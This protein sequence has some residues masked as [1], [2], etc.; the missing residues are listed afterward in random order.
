M[1]IDENTKRFIFDRL[2]WLGIYTGI[3]FLLLFLLPFPYD[4]FSILALF[5]LINFLRGRSILKSYG[6]TGGI[7]DSF[8][9]FSS[10]MSRN[11]QSRPLKY[12]CMNCGKEHKETAYPNCGSK[13]KRVG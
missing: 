12:Y 11:N 5:I 8:G 4:F 1:N 2:K 13:M 3:S 7:K 6:R 9:S 10:S